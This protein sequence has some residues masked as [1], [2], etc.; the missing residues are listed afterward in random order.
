[1]TSFTRTRKVVT[2]YHVSF[3]GQ[4]SLFLLD[5]IQLPSNRNFERNG[6]H[7]ENPLLFMCG[8]C[9]EC[10][11]RARSAGIGVRMFLHRECSTMLPTHSYQSETEGLDV[12]SSSYC[13]K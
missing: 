6:C 8:F 3:R 7:E 5:A 4:T 1:M 12:V 9:Q 11:L 10:R 13:S 2:R